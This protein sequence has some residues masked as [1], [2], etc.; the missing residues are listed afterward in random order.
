MDSHSLR[1][2]RELIVER[3]DVMHALFDKYVDSNDFVMS[4]TMK[5]LI[6]DDET[7]LKEIEATLLRLGP[8]SLEEIEAVEKRMQE[9]DDLVSE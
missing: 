3:Q 6:S 5:R 8:P 9:L 7:E 2:R 4:A 1:V